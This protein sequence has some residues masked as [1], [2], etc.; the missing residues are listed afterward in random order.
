[1]KQK[2]LFRTLYFSII[3]MLLFSFTACNK[4]DSNSEIESTDNTNEGKYYVLAEFTTH[5]ELN[6]ESKQMFSFDVDGADIIWSYSEFDDEYKKFV[7]GN[8]TEQIKYKN[9]A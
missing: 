6:N 9:T 4:H 1:M 7:N 8:L 2:K 3:A 5:N